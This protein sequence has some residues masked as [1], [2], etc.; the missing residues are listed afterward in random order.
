[1]K[2]NT[3]SLSGAYTALGSAENFKKRDGDVNIFII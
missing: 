2:K 3:V 1:M